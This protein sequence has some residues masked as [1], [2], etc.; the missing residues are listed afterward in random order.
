MQRDESTPSVEITALLRDWQTGDRD[1]LDRMIPLVYREL[2]V[3]A[4]RLM[5]REWRDGTIQTTGLVNEAYLKLVDQRQVD[6]QGRAH[7][8]AIAAQVMRRILLDAA[9][10]RMREKRGGGAVQLVIDD[11]PVATRAAP[12]DA[13]DVLAIDRALRDLE[14]LDADQAKMV[15]LRFFGGLT[16]EETSAVLGVS[17]ATVKREW[18]VAKGWLYRALTSGPGQPRA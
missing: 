9:R 13:I 7:F 10:R 12:V 2:H 8:F 14:Q 15:E 16:I 6:W 5:S 4:S 3:M 1:A 11:L 17:P 18:A